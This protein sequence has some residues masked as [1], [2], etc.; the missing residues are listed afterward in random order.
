MNI[1][2]GDII[3]CVITAQL[4]AVETVRLQEQT[5]SGSITYSEKVQPGDAVFVQL[6]MKFANTTLNE[7]LRNFAAALQLFKGKKT[8]ASA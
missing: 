6:S 8:A 3:C 7:S 2:M 1:F 4:F 5:D